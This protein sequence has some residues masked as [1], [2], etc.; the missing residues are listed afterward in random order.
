MKQV[1]W[2]ALSS[3][4]ILSVANELVVT[5]PVDMNIT[6]TLQMEKR[7]NKLEQRL[8]KKAKIREEKSQ[9]REARLKKLDET[10]Q[11]KAEKRETIHVRG[12]SRDIEDALKNS[13]SMK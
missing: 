6:H 5:S 1:L 12:D 4:F 2:L 10:L 13:K 7:L 9:I 3:I 11:V 8:Q